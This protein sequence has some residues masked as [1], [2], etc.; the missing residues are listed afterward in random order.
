MAK[1]SDESAEED[2]KDSSEKKKEKDD[3]D[4][5]VDKETAADDSSETRKSRKRGLFASQKTCQGQKL[6]RPN[7]LNKAQAKCDKD[8]KKP[9][10]PVV[11]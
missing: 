9:K 4:D 1:S 5:D 10:S 2:L 6:S 11:S 3:D 7:I 8:K